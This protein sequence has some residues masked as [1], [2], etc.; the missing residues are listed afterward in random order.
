M[1]HALALLHPSGTSPKRQ[2]QQH[3][4]LLLQ[5]ALSTAGQQVA[6]PVPAP[7]APPPV[8]GAASAL[9]NVPL[10]EQ[11]AQLVRH[12]QRPPP[13]QPAVHAQQA[14]AQQVQPGQQLPQQA[15]TSPTSPQVQAEA[16]QELQR[17]LHQHQQG[18]WPPPPRQ[19]TTELLDQVKHAAQDLLQLLT[20]SAS[21]TGSPRGEQW[22]AAAPPLPL[23]QL[24]A[25]GGPQPAEPAQP[26]R[27][28]AAPAGLDPELVQ[29]LASGLTEA[30]AGTE[31]A[32]AAL[33]Q[34]VAFLGSK[35]PNP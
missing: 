19:T 30:R 7:A 16:A 11:L 23:P 27:L 26:A 14:A 33:H 18:S 32:A 6:P 9:Q 15:P 4:I 34:L 13:P 21:L 22:Q 2:Q 25:S 31:S 8:T 28:A 35:P 20:L 12:L 24:P 3:L 17:L 1:P 5:E 10:T 29:L